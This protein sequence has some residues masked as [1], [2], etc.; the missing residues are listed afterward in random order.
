MPISNPFDHPMFNMANLTA[1]INE[2]DAQF[3]TVSSLGLFQTKRLTTR[4]AIIE[5]KA[6]SPTLLAVKPVG[7]PGDENTGPDRKS[8]SFNVPHIPLDDVILPEDYANVRAFG[9]ENILQT[10]SEIMGDKLFSLRQSHELTFDFMM[11]GAIKGQIKDG[12]GNVIYNLFDE[13]GL[14]QITVSFALATDTTDVAA[15][16]RE[17]KRTI[18]RKAKGQRITGFKALCAPDFYDKLINHPSVRETFLNH[19]AAAS[20]REDSVNGFTFGNITFIECSDIGV[21]LNGNEVKY[22][23]DGTAY[24]FPVGTLLFDIY[25]APAD[26]IETVNTR[27]KRIYV[28]QEPRKYNR[29]IDIHSQSNP[30]PICLNPEVCVKLTV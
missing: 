6:F 4:T 22:V 27:G 21:D 25:F 16:C 14:S 7:S 23:E 18:R 15:K 13:F 26:F 29:G 30:L 10:L 1:A 19:E 3:G 20:L 8:I 9:Q 12:K 11:M 28:K 5:K 17:V 24:A 2:I